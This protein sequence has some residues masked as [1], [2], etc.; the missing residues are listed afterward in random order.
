MSMSAVG[1]TEK[2][3]GYLL[4]LDELRA[5]P[6]LAPPKPELS[7]RA[8]KVADTWIRFVLA[9]REFVADPER[10]DALARLIQ[11]EYGA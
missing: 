1:Y 9:G 4:A 6:I 5:L 8:K 11:D 2:N 7:Q 10:R 3:V